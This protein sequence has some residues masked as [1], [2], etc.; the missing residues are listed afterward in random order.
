VRLRLITLGW[1]V[2]FIGSTTLIWTR[3]SKDYAVA[4][5]TVYAGYAGYD[6]SGSLI[7]AISQLG[8]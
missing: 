4:G 7:P 3:D 5:Q 8:S 2:R 6:A 1:N